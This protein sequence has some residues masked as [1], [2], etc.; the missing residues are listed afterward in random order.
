MKLISE[1]VKKLLNK[2]APGATLKNYRLDKTPLGYSIKIHAVH[3]THNIVIYA[4][5][6][7]YAH[8]NKHGYQICQITNTNVAK[9]GAEMKETLRQKAWEA[10]VDIA[11]RQDPYLPI[12][13]AATRLALLYLVNESYLPKEGK[14]QVEVHEENL[15]Q[16]LGITDYILE[17]ILYCLELNG[18]ITKISAKPE[19]RINL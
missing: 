8:L 15:C 7:K 18:H 4:Y 19:Y 3:D 11:K 14:S 12:S 10:Q 6:Y 2:E 5:L 9:I 16:F 13:K 17:E 1:R